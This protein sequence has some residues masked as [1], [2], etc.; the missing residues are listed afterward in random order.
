MRKPRYSVPQAL[1][2][3]EPIKGRDCPTEPLG[4]NHLI[5]DKIGGKNGF[6]AGLVGAYQKSYK[7]KMELTKGHVERSYK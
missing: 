1:R 6:Q 7:Y 5:M 3:L 4:P 2:T